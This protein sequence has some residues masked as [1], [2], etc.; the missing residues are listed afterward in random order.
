MKLFKKSLFICFSL[1]LFLIPIFAW[2]QTSIELSNPLNVTSIEE[3]AINIA[4]FIFLV[5]TA[6]APLMLV[7]AGFYFITSSGNPQ[8]VETAKKIILYTLIGY[9]II[10]ISRGLIFIIRDILGTT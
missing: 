8:Q 4:N 7:I 9:C 3:L 10:F 6:L 2:G 5:A 1:S